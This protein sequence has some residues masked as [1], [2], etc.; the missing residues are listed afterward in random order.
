MSLYQEL[1]VCM[2]TQK[3]FQSQL[4]HIHEAGCYTVLYQPY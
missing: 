4:E 1:W 2:V 3:S